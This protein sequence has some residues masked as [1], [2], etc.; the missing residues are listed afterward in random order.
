MGHMASGAIAGIPGIRPEIKDAINEQDARM[1]YNLAQFQKGMND[2]TDDAANKGVQA[3]AKTG[4]V[5]QALTDQ[6]KL[7]SGQITDAQLEGSRTVFNPA[8]WVGPAEATKGIGLVV[9]PEFQQ[10]VKDSAQAIVNLKAEETS[11][12]S[13]VGAAQ[14][15]KQNAINQTLGDSGQVI[16]DLREQQAVA[17]TNLS[18]AQ[19]ARTAN[20]PPDGGNPH[21]QFDADISIAQSRLDAVRQQ[22]EAATAAHPTSPPPGYGSPGRPLGFN[23]PGDPGTPG[24]SAPPPFVPSRDWQEIPK[25]MAMPPGGQYRMDMGGGPNFA[26]WDNPP[27]PVKAAPPPPGQGVPFPPMPFEFDNQIAAAQSHLA[28]IRSDIQ[29]ATADHQQIVINAGNA[30]QRNVGIA[31]QAAAGLAQGGAAVIGKVNDI[32]TAVSKGIENWTL[33]LANGDP[34][35]AAAIRHYVPDMIGAF[36]GYMQGGIHGAAESGFMTHALTYLPALNAKLEPFG[37]SVGKIA[38][39]LSVLGK[40]F[41]AGQVT[42]SFA[43]RLGQKLVGVPQ[44][45]AKAMV[46]VPSTM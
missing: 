34:Q 36:Q 13:R 25:G 9:K 39:N 8:N 27:P 11:A 46:S 7:S 17:A 16:A 10:A 4:L 12:M 14:I 30:L 37:L 41:G 5:S 19:D 18:K 44:T 45:I 6:I 40:E 23:G 42:S 32:G 29:K 26:R 15:L 2:W 3:L 43:N 31:S 1:S 21:P 38:Y 24:Y 22:L 35:A 20:L 28:G 33:K